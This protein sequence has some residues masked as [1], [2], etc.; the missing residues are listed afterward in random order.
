MV[1][2]SVFRLSLSLLFIVTV[3]HVDI[4]EI[5]FFFVERYLWYQLVL[6]YGWDL[7][8]SLHWLIY[9]SSIDISYCSSVFFVFIVKKF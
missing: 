2:A 7:G 4:N 9:H 3:Q 1:S 8:T 5:F 6:K